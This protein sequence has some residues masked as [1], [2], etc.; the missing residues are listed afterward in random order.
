VTEHCVALR[1]DRTDTLPSPR[2]RKALPHRNTIMLILEHSGALLLEKRP[3]PG[4]WG[5]LWCFPE[6]STDDDIA[7]ACVQRF[8]ACI[9][10]MQRLPDLEHGF[11]HFSLTITPHRLQVCALQPR[12]AEADYQWLP[13]EQLQAA[14]V[15][16]PV[17]RIV[18]LLR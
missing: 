9:G 1:E 13:I 5:G 17:K 2:P 3:A 4:I 15:P 12:A 8:G 10:A 14:P 11:T 6:A 16:A 7:T 18:A